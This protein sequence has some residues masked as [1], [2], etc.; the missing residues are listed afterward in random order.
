MKI[1]FADGISESALTRLREGGAECDLNA[2]LTADTLPEHIA[3]YDV[4]V[5][6]STRVTAAAI[7]ASTSLGLIVRAGAGTNTIDCERAAERGV[8]VCNVPG[9]NAIAVAELALG[10]MFAIDRQI[11]SA[12]ADLRA[13][14]WNKKLYSKGSGIY[15][16]NLGIVG[17]GAIGLEVAKRGAAC[18]MSIFALD[19]P[20]RDAGTRQQL[21]ALNVEYKPDLKTLL[22]DS[23]IVT[24]HVPSKPET[25]K[26]VNA[27][28]LSSMK[29]DAILINT[30]RG[31]VVDEAALLNALNNTDLRAGLDVFDN[32]PTT[33]TGEFQSELAAHLKVTGTHHIGA[34]TKQAQEAV[35]DGTVE[36]IQAYAQGTVMHCVNLQQTPAGVDTLIVRHDDRVGVLAEVLHQLRSHG[37]YIANMSNRV[38]TGS[39]AGIVTIELSGEVSESLLGDVS[40]VD[41]V[42]QASVR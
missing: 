26:M 18:G 32:E 33:P 30:S 34:S 14:V 29:P 8:L 23:D 38:F 2:S 13:G 35:A 21:K 20:N 11:A 16:S 36:L 17:M 5:V 41:G 42:I 19:N 15:G 25:A 27:D 9:R 24:L 3:G 4:L 28:F 10:L 22:A 12:T 40:K 1:L 31:E 39:V 37:L 6:R 7:D